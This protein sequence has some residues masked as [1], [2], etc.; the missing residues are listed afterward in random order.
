MS[1]IGRKKAWPIEKIRKIIISLNKR[2]RIL[3]LIEISKTIRPKII[4][5]TR[6]FKETREIQQTIRIILKVRN[7]QIIREILPRTFSAKTL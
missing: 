1:R 5:I 2:R 7:L 4:L 3:C 6:I